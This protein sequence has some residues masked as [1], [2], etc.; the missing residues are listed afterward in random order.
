[1]IGATDDFIVD[2]ISNME[3]A[4]YYAVDNNNDKNKGQG[5]P[6]YIDS[7]HDVMLGS[8]WKNGASTLK[9]WI[10]DTVVTF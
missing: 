7:Y 1:V 4:M 9:E 2:E 5:Q 6:V 8:K 10:E 3:T